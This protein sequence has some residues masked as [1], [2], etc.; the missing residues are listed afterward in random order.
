MTESGPDP[1][2]GKSSEIRYSPYYELEQRS[3]D[4]AVLARLV[5]TL[6]GERVPKGYVFTGPFAGDLK[7]AHRD[8]IVEWVTEVYFI[9]TSAK[10]IS[11]TPKQVLDAPATKKQVEILPGQ[12]YI[13]AP[14]VSLHSNYGTKQKVSFAYEY[15]GK[16]YLV[17]GVAQRL[18]VEQVSAKYGRH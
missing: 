16:T 4:Q 7:A 3:D 14:I 17:D 10:P 1:A 15:G 2:T 11:V 9:N 8:G 6:G 18:T 5:I 12:W 13:T